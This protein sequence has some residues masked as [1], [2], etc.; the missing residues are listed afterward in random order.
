[1]KMGEASKLHVE[2]ISTG[3]IGLDSVLGVGGFPRGRI[4]EIF[5]PE[6]GGKTT[7]SLQA[8]GAAQKQGGT[9]AFI[10]AEHS[11][12][13]LYAKKIGEDCISSLFLYNFNQFLLF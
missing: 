11:M 4:I 1:M 2:V 6:S 5:G 9:A 8:I 7:V 12:D 13:P 10:D 3:S